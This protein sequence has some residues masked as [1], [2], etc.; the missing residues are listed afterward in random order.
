MIRKPILACLLALLPAV[1][2]AG[3][4]K[5]IV[6]A[7]PRVPTGGV[8][9][10]NGE[11]SESDV[12]VQWQVL[13]DAATPLPLISLDK[14]SRKGVYAVAFGPPDG[15][16]NFA[17]IA[18]GITPGAKPED[19]PAVKVAVKVVTVTVGPLTPIKPDPPPGPVPTDRTERLGYDYA[20]AVLGAVDSAFDAAARG[21][22]DSTADL[23]TA[24]RKAFS[25]ALTTAF[26][27][28]A[29]ELT[30][31]VGEPS[32]QPSARDVQAVQEYIKKIQSGARAAK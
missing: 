22:Y 32:A 29:S 16:Y 10:L 24:Q 20:K 15:T 14:D 4:P 8:I 3:E 2:P 13:G 11:K 9:F 18:V 30:R 12:P 21:R 7:P 6:E 27:P 5:A 25:E 19:K 31:Q 17:L 1:A 28:V 26:G 23:A